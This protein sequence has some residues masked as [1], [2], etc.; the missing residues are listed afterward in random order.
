[1][2]LHDNFLNYG[3]WTKVCNNYENNLRQ[4]RHTLKGIPE[5]PQELT[6]LEIAVRIVAC[7]YYAYAD[8]RIKL[9]NSNKYTNASIDLNNITLSENSYNYDN[10]KNMPKELFYI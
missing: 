3:N 10:N 5:L 4:L 2:Y 9:N 6:E 8:N 7:F 1:M